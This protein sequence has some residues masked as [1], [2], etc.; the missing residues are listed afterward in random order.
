M[1]SVLILS[2]VMDVLAISSS[3]TFEGR[4]VEWIASSARDFGSWNTSEFVVL[5]P[6]I[7]LEYFQRRRETGAGPRPLMLDRRDLL[8]PCRMPGN[9]PYADCSCS[10]GE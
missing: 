7:G 8:L 2:I 6:E 9:N 1:M 5:D 3:S 10:N 4:G